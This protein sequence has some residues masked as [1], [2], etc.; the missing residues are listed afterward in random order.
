MVMNPVLH[1]GSVTYTLMNFNTW[2]GAMCHLYNILTPYMHNAFSPLPSPSILPYP[3]P[4]ATPL[5]V[6]PPTRSHSLLSHI[7]TVEDA[8]EDDSNKED[9]CSVVQ[10]DWTEYDVTN[11]N[12]YPISYLNQW[13]HSQ[14]CP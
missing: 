7:A 4:E 2:C 13:G 3:L 10:Q 12:H 9:P 11:P 8:L 6:P 14:T 1:E 5:P